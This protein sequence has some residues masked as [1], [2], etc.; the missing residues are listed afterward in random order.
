MAQ[1][2]SRKRQKYCL[3]YRDTCCF[4][5]WPQLVS[6]VYVFWITLIKKFPQYPV[7]MFAYVSDVHIAF[8]AQLRVLCHKNFSH[9]Y[10]LVAEPPPQGKSSS[11][12][13]LLYIDVHGP[14]PFGFGGFHNAGSNTVPSDQSHVPSVDLVASVQSPPPS[15]LQPKILNSISHC[16]LDTSAQNHV[17]TTV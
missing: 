7:F 9:M 13:S 15:P 3:Y 2:G 4:P 10:S 16:L 14:F 5:E 6:T 11:L 1:Q 17:Q 8:G 12:N